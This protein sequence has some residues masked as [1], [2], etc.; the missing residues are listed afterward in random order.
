MPA[1]SGPPGP[2]MGR[3]ALFDKRGTGL[4]EGAWIEASTDDMVPDVLTVMDAIG[5]EQL[6]ALVGWTDAAAIAMTVAAMHPQRVS[7]LVLGEV[8]AT[9]SPDEDH[10]WGPDPRRS[11]R[12][13]E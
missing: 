4:S 7:A 13:P 11:R 10:P 8:L 3:V 9:S 6:A 12:W 2:G 1:I 5:M